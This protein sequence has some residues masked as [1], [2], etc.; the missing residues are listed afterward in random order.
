MK[1]RAE[2]DGLRAV[3]VLLVVLFHADGNLCSGGYIGVD[4]FFV[5]SGYLITSII[6]KQIGD[7]TFSLL[8][9]YERRAR[10]ILPAFVVVV[11]CVL[12]ASWC[13]V[14]PSAFKA[15]GRAAAASSVSL[16][17]VLFW[18][19]DGYFAAASEEKPLLHTWS[20]GV[21]EQFY[22]LLPYLF[23]AFG[24]G[25]KSTWGMSLTFAIS[26]AVSVVLVRSE[27]SAA[28]F[29]IPARAWE[30]L[31]GSLLS[32]QMASDRS[33]PQG[34]HTVG[35]LGLLVILACGWS[36]TIGTAF[37][38]ENA[39]L[40][41]LGAAAVIYG[42]RGGI[43]CRLLSV[44][45][46]VFVG[47]ISYSLYLWHW[48]ILVFARQLK[49]MPLTG[50]ETAACVAVSFAL[51]I[52]SWKYVE[53]PFRAG[54]PEI[55]RRTVFSM[56]CISLASYAC[57]GAYVHFNDGVPARF[58]AI[59]VRLDDGS[60]DSGLRA[61]E[62][63]AIRWVRSD[64]AVIYGA[65]VSPNF[66][67]LGDSHSNV[68]AL[69]LGRSAR[70]R[71]ES[72]RHFYEFGAAPVL[73]VQ[74]AGNPGADDRIEQAVQLIENS[75]NI[76]T[77][78]LIARW[79][80]VI[81]GFNAD[82][83]SYERGRSDAPGILKPSSSR[84][85]TTDEASDLFCEGI[86][87]TVSRLKLAGKRVVVMYP[88]PEVGYHVPRTM[89]RFLHYHGSVEEFVRPASYY[90]HRQ[91][92][93]FTVLD[94]LGDS[95]TRVFPHEFFLRGDRAIVQESHQPLYRDDDHLS[96][97]GA[98]KLMPMFE[99]VLWPDPSYVHLANKNEKYE[100]L[101][102]VENVDSKIERQ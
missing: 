71:G 92:R 102:G 91:E 99:H 100:L 23:L 14:L 36:Y 86:T 46:L 37:P 13:F 59:V 30:L 43:V 45:P 61:D 38:G 96:I 21:E 34:G 44:N 41:C 74:F 90:F 84:R 10:R 2:I 22:F 67:I 9:F 76:E 6:R 80:Y 56:S 48:P 69:T 17:N 32:V 27:P 68:L 95:V 89:A 97:S 19:E 18:A 52:L 39:L 77:V 35:L 29:L 83:G 51:A 8:G 20:L 16:S 11:A 75:E 87:R 54:Q 101:S 62:S 5:I 40:P 3:A 33:I 4:V 70:N 60:H 50:W 7:E 28:F 47:K 1:Y 31:L 94:S 65:Q 66:A 42:G 82:F 25:R 57:L 98:R 26:L 81:H 63:A 58:S 79:A 64:G 49:I 85:I 72:L 55:S 78:V 73:G 15:V 88:I 53:Q 93:V 12:V 24:V